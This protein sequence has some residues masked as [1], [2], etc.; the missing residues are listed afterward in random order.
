MKRIRFS[1]AVSL[2]GY[3]AGPNGEADWI[4]P[5]PERDFPTLIA[6]F[7]TLLVG[8]R[9][10][11][12]MVRRKRTTMLGMRTVVLSTTLR[13]VDHP[14]VTIVSEGVDAAVRRL[15][16]NS[17]KDVWLFGGGEVFGRLLACGLVD[18]VELA[19]Q[20]VLLGGGIPLL[21][22]TLHRH[23]LHLA[24]HRV[25]QVGVVHLEYAAQHSAA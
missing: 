5:D 14:E 8:R 15:R 12:T 24:A 11:E 10:F 21:R 7:D 20:P 4:V 3:I 9:T 19:V 17:Q 23:R 16:A 6:Q 13:Q 1:A 25:S 22:E 18:G 2:D